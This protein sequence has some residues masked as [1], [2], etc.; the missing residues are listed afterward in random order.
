M[1][2][3]TW[4]AREA[5]Q[6]V[7]WLEKTTRGDAKVADLE[8]AAADAQGFLGLNLERLA[9]SQKAASFASRSRDRLQQSRQS[10]QTDQFK[11]ART[12]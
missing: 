1:R 2:L 3:T 11:E 9:R 5:T 10:L 12:R 8:R 6:V 4:V 7:K